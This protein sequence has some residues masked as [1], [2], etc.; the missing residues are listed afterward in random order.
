MAYV[1]LTKEEKE[2]LTPE[3]KVN[4]LLRKFKKQVKK[5]DILWQYKMNEFFIQKK[6]KRLLKKEHSQLKKK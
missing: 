5:D 3:E 2:S 1:Y 6:T 4:L